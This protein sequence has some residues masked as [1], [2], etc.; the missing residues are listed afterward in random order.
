MRADTDTFATVNAAFLGDPGFTVPHANRFGRT[1]LDAVGAAHTLGFIEPHGMKFSHDSFSSWFRNGP[2][3]LPSAFADFRC[4]GHLIGI[5]FNIRQSHP[6]AETH[7]AGNIGAVDQ[8]SC[9][10]RSTSG[11]PGP[12]SMIWM[13][14]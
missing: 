4:D 12:W 10:A 6:G 11:I 13:T 9:M 8:P 7:F 1:F 2:Q 14:M 5:F 3:S